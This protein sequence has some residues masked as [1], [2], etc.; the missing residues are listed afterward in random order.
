MTSNR[1]TP[2]YFNAIK[3]LLS[4][5]WGH[6]LKDTLSLYFTRS[7]RYSKELFLFENGLFNLCLTFA[8]FTKETRII[9]GGSHLLRTPV[10]CWGHPYESR[11][12]AVHIANEFPKTD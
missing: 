8:P 4:R 7:Y 12:P 3:L 11:H 1:I 2:L 9:N 6:L 10:F 5:P